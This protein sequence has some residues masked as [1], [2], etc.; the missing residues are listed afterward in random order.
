LAVVSGTTKG[1]LAGMSLVIFHGHAFSGRLPL[2]TIHVVANLLF[3]GLGALLLW[4]ALMR[5]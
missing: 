5:T 2:K 4:R 1:M 3:L